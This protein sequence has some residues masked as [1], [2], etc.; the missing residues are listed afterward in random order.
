[1]HERLADGRLKEKVKASGGPWGGINVDENYMC[2]LETIFGEKAFAEFKRTQMEDYLDI[3][4][5]FETKKR[6]FNTSSTDRIT[7]KVAAQLN[8]LSTT[9]TMRTLEQNIAESCYANRVLVKG[10][11][12]MRVDPS[13]VREWFDGPV[14]ALIYHTKELFKDS[15]TSS[16]KTILLVGGFG[17]SCYVQEKMKR[18]F[19]DKNIIVPNEAGLVVLKGAVRFGHKSN[20]IESRIVK[21]SYGLRANNKYREGFHPAETQFIGKDGVKRVKNGFKIFV[22]ANAEIRVGHEVTRN[23]RLSVGSSRSRIPVYRTPNPNPV[24]TTESGCEI[25]GILRVPRPKSTGNFDPA[26]YVTLTIGDTELMVKV[27]VKE[28]AEEFNLTLNCL[29]YDGI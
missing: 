15:M 24:F 12:K 5:E 19:S 11:D 16:T 18:A 8:T 29:E 6:N 3:L 28:T 23:C 21:Y 1:M 7:F 27:K 14:D 9:F 2:M 20:V 26:I 17:E 13:V 22:K 10:K 4:R 25:L